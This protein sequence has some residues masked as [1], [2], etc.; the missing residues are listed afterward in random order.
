MTRPSRT[1]RVLPD[2]RAE[3]LGV[4]FPC[5]LGS[6]GVRRVK[7]EGDGGT[8]VGRFPV[9]RLYWRP[10]RLDRPRTGLPVMPLRPSAGW[11]DDP[12]SPAYNRP[13]VLPFAASHERM[14]RTDGLYDLVL[15]IGHNDRPA[16]PGHGSAVFVHVAAPGFTP[17]AGCVAFTPPDLLAIVG[18]LAPGDRVRIG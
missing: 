17:T 2:G 14:W 9:R 11:C 12:A 4:S 7:R 6:G 18:E 8:P 15:V 3:F 16:V 10:D 13:V 1:L 5:A